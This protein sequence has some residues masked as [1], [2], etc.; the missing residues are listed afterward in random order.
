[1]TLETIRAALGWCIILNW[2]MLLFWF[3]MFR[4]ARD[5]MLRIHSNWFNLSSGSYDTIHF[6]GMA[7]FK[8]WIILFNL[9]P[10][11]ALRIVG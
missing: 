9:V 11:L 7:V 8:I 2:G 1:M 10:Y 6:S 3:L 5:W 4:F